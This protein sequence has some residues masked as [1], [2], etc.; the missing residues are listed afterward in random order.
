M[1]RV[2]LRDE[3]GMTLIEL[4]VATSAGIV[5]LFGI[6]AAM[7]VTLHQTGRVTSH[8]DAD[9]RARIA[10]TKVVNQ[11]HSACV[12]PRIA[13]VREGSDT[14]L[15]F[16]HQTGSEV[17]P[18]PIKSTISLNGETL[19]EANYE[20]TGGTAPEWQYANFPTKPTSEE[21]LA[22][23]ISPLSTGTPIFSYF[24]YSGGKVESTRLATPFK[25]EVGAKVAQVNVAFQAAPLTTPN[26]ND[27]GASTPIQSAVTLR[28][29]PPA[30][31]T[32]TSDLPCQ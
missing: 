8:V 17:E 1:T 29:T 21:I 3:R 26:A 5:V 15:T 32:E 13:P 12:M 30:Y 2:D 20:P 4:L 25:E 6:V 23:G 22:T 9:Q 16:L 27:T 31:S 7:I 14:A 19:R 11:L 18:T 24:A 28:L 10:M